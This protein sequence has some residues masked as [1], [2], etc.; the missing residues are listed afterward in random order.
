MKKWGRE[1]AGERPPKSI[2]M[3][4]YVYDINKGT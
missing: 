1:E 2:C 3:W 4:P